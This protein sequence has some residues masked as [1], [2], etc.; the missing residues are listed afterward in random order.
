[1]FDAEHGEANVCKARPDHE[2]ETKRDLQVEQTAEAG[3]ETAIHAFVFS[4]A[5][6]AHY[7]FDHGNRNSLYGFNTYGCYNRTGQDVSYRK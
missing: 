3:S 1:M 6:P 4:A 5:Q 7:K 2:D